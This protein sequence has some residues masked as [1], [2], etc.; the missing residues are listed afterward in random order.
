MTLVEAEFGDVSSDWERGLS[1]PGGLHK[2][3]AGR[4]LPASSLTAVSWHL[5]ERSGELRD[6]A[7]EMKAF[8]ETVRAC[9][10]RRQEEEGGGVIATE[11]EPREQC[12]GEPRRA[13][14]L[15]NITVTWPMEMGQEWPRLL[16]T[17]VSS[18]S[19]NAAPICPP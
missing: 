15:A 2:A 14:P 17:E 8:L 7:F 13:I 9:S 1:A 18:C 11:K 16:L 4:P 12:A 3:A 19:A 10:R 5:H 6:R